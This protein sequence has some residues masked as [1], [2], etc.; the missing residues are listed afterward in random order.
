[1]SYPPLDP[2]AVAGDRFILPEGRAL[3]VRRLEASDRRG[4]EALFARLSDESRRRRFLHPKPVVTGAEIRYLR[5]VGGARHGALAV[6]DEDSGELV[7]EARYAAWNDREDTADV[8][9]TVADDLHGRRIGTALMAALVAWACAGGFARLTG[10][11]LLENA[12][13]LAMLRR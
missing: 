6:V 5:D 10:S 12:A 3:R 7:A 4:L 1:M 8:A 13:S 2:A 11:T 9:V